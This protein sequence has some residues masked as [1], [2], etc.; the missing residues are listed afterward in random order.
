MSFSIKVT[1][2]SDS[3]INLDGGEVNADIRPGDSAELHFQ[4]DDIIV[5][6]RHDPMAA[7]ESDESE[8][9]PLAPPPVNGQPDGTNPP[10]GGDTNTEG[11]GVG[12][13]GTDQAKDT[14][15]ADTAASN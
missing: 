9:E 7:A 5:V 2:R 11:D 4:D 15:P 14:P 10:A 6:T 12:S 1:N 13:G 3:Y 8:G